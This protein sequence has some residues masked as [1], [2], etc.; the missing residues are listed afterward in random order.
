M[1]KQLL[2]G[3]TLATTLLLGACSYSTDDLAKEVR[4]NMAE[5]LSQDAGTA[6]VEITDFN[7]VHIDG[8]QYRGILK[9]TEHGQ[10]FTYTV[11]VTF[12][13]KNFMWEIEE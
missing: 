5:T 11:N 6:H 9:T 12:D 7:L 1:L 8:K 3:L 10:K 4:A 13:G 2:A